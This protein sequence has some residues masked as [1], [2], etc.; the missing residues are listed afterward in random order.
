M[1]RLRESRSMQMSVLSVAVAF[2]LPLDLA[3]SSW[4]CSCLNQVS[5]NVVWWDHSS[6]SASRLEELES[7]TEIL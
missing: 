4:D 6:T 7:D 5:L 1:Q 3:E 2:C